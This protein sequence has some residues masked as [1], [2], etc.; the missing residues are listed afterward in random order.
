MLRCQTVKDAIDSVRALAVHINS[1]G[2]VTS[3]DQAR[4]II[5]THADV[6][7]LCA[8]CLNPRKYSMTENQISQVL[9]CRRK[10]F[11]HLALCLFG[12]VV[13]LAACG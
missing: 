1:Y 5:K 12:V 8:P 9:N 2:V 3:E 4:F 13:F 7:I 10:S 6:V 11:D